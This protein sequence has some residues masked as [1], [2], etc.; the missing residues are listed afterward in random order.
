MK[1]IYLFNIVARNYRQKIGFP[2]CK[3]KNFAG[4]QVHRKS[5]K[6]ARAS[7]SPQ[8]SSPRKCFWDFYSWSPLFLGFQVIQTGY[9]PDFNIECVLLLK[10]Y[11][12]D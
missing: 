3:K 11:Y 12:Y 7:P 4:L 9:W 5:G 6:S 2:V 10:M 8:H 1:Q